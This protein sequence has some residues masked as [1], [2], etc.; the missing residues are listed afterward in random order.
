VIDAPTLV[1]VVAN[2]VAVSIEHQIVAP[3]LI[4]SQA[5]DLLLAAVRRGDV[6]EDDALEQH[7]RFTQFKMRVLGDRMSRRMAWKI[8]QQNGWDTTLDAE[9]L[10]VCKL[11]ADAFITIDE[12]LAVRA[13]GIV[14][15]A[16][17]SALGAS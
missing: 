3:S 10:A 12:H 2:Q 17:L 14:S 13:A 1:Y 11:Q 9:Y 7:E 15:L 4:R 16:P 6:T 8:A 5:L